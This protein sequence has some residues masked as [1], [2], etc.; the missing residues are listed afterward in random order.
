MTLSE[1]NEHRNIVEQWRKAQEQLTEL[2]AKELGAASYDG[3]P[4]S[5]TVGNRTESLAIMLARNR[6]KV[7]EWK[8]A[9]DSSQK[10]IMSFIDTIDDVLTFN[11]F[12]YR[13]IE[14]LDWKD[15]AAQVKGG[16]TV[17]SV[18]SICYRYLGLPNTQSGTVCPK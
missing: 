8:R 2:E 1:L 12:V 5:T 18:K 14:C 6:E 13:F 4:H 3:M 15:V 10:R 9:K 11:I 16:N 7:D 17:D